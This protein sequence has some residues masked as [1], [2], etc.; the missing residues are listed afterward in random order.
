M[1]DFMSL[2]SLGVHQ[3]NRI[4]ANC[5]LYVNCKL[6]FEIPDECPITNDS[7]GMNLAI[8]LTVISS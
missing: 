5:Y 2:L 1:Y 8:Y 3:S 6:G 7:I 4:F